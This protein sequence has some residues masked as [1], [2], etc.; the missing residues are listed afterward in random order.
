[1]TTKKQKSTK[2]E[3][4]KESHLERRFRNIWSVVAADLPLESQ[5]KGVVPGRRFIYDFYV[6]DAGVLIECNGGVW[7]RG[8]SGHSSGTGIQ[9]DAEK[10]NAAQINGYAI[11]VFTPDKLTTEYVSNVAEFCRARVNNQTID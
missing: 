10:T 3:A 7:A 8:Q 4:I 6:P 9:R 2:E 1:M 5:K 11:F